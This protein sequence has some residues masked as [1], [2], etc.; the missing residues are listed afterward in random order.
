ML[1][2]IFSILSA[3]CFVIMILPL[4]LPDSTRGFSPL[5]V[6][7]N[8]HLF[9]PVFL[10]MVGIVLGVIG[11]KGQVRLYLVLFNLF[12]L[13]FYILATLMGLYGFNEP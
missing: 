10:G 3:L 12:V 2:K 13:G 9:F 11:L 5:D 1:K 6:I 8:I 4:I 7:F